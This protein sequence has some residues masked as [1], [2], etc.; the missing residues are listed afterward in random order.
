VSDVVFKARSGT[1]P[2]VETIFRSAPAFPYVMNVWW[3]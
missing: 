2:I 3:I 1:G